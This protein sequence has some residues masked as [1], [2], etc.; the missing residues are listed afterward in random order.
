MAQKIDMD[1]VVERVVKSL[2]GDERME[3]KVVE[4]LTKI[5]SGEIDVDDD[6]SDDEILTKSQ[7]KALIAK[8]LE[9]DPDEEEEDADGDEEEEDEEEEEAADGEEEEEKDSSSE[10][11]FDR[12]E[13]KSLLKEVVREELKGK[14]VAK[15]AKRSVSKGDRATDDDFDPKLCKRASDIPAGWMEKVDSGDVPMVDY[16]SLPD[17]V[18]TELLVKRFRPAGK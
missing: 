13:L 14:L 6:E 1:E 9:E 5:A 8:A 3:A 12:S 11:S 17:H 2:E 15:G 18:R 16:E 7:V 4:V 10:K